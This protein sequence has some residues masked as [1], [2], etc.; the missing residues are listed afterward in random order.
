MPHLKILAGFKDG[1]TCTGQDRCFLVLKP[2]V[3]ALL[4][5]GYLEA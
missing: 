5:A 1:T 2:P 3:S 4:R